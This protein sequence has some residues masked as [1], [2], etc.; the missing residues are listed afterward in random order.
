[1]NMLAG[2]QPVISTIVRATRHDVIAQIQG[3]AEAEL[4]QS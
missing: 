4:K 3:R 1:M 2:M